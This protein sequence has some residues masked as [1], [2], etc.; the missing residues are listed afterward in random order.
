MQNDPK[1][2]NIQF[3]ESN[4]TFIEKIDSENI[5]T[6]QKILDKN[7][8]ENGKNKTANRINQYN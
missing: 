3:G 2:D 1:A 5:K 4:T 7:G 8:M 6:K